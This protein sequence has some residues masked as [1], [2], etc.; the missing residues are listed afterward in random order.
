MATSSFTLNKK[1]CLINVTK[2]PFKSQLPILFCSL[3][4]IKI[5]GEKYPLNCCDGSREHQFKKLV[6]K[7]IG[8][9]LVCFNKQNRELNDVVSSRSHRSQPCFLLF[10]QTGW[11][12][13]L[14]RSLRGCCWTRLSVG[15]HRCS[16]VRPKDVDIKPVR[17]LSQFRRE[18]VLVRADKY[19]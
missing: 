13:C 1:I 7:I 17:S 16:L 6:N 12:L 15:L 14:S 18:T 3:L 9:I 19:I 11:L 10:S 2:Q 8:H 4:F 5:T